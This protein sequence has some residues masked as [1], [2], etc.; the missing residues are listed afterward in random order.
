MSTSRSA[1][2]QRYGYRVTDRTTWLQGTGS[3]RKAAPSAKA[4]DTIRAIDA[5]FGYR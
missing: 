3:I 4:I 1:A 5:L 2:E